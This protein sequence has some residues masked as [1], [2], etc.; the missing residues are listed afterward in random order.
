[1]EVGPVQGRPGVGEGHGLR[2]VRGR[3]GRSYEWAGDQGT[4]IAKNGD[5]EGTA[6][7]GAHYGGGRRQHLRMDPPSSAPPAFLQ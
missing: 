5:K 1:M 3:R 4:K 7:P 6:G 2:G